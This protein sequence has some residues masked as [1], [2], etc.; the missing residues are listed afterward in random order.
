M[1]VPQAVSSW[2]HRSLGPKHLS[3]MSQNREGGTPFR[4]DKND[5]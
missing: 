2:F 3:T 1:I 4:M 5:L